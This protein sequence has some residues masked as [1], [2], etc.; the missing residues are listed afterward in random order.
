MTRGHARIAGILRLIISAFIIKCV[1][2]CG[3]SRQQNN[4]KDQVDGPAAYNAWYRSLR[5]LAKVL[6]PGRA[7]VSPPKDRASF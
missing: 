7:S 3:Y 5:P 4:T 1:A 6:P 2:M